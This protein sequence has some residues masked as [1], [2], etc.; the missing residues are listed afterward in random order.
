MISGVV[1]DLA[2]IQRNATVDTIDE[3]SLRTLAFAMGPGVLFMIGC[4]VLA[5][6][7]YDL[8]QAEHSRIRRAL[9]AH[10][11]NL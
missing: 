1:V 7:F 8:S 4:T 3:E 10:E 6:A 5:A 11:R 9:E 2:G